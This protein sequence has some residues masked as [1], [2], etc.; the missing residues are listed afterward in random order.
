M[1]NSIKP[2][3]DKN[4]IP[5]VFATDDNF[6]PYLYVAMYSLISNADENNNYDINIL[7]SK[8][9]EH[10][11]SRL[12]SLAQKNISIRFLDMTEYMNK[13]SDV[14]YTHWNYSDAVYYRFF[15]S[16]IFSNYEKVLYLDGDVIFN[17]DIAELYN[18]ELGKNYIAAIQDISQQMQNYVG[19]KYREN[20]LNIKRENYFNAGII[21]FNIKELQKISFFDN[22]ISTLAQLKNPV[23]QD[24]DVLNKV[25]D[26]HVKYLPYNYNL[27]WNCL[28]Y[29]TD[30]K[31][32]MPETTYNE[33]KEAWKNP[34]IIHYAG[35]YKPWKQP[36]LEY[37]D[38]FWKY[39]RQTPFYEE[40][41]YNNCK[42]ETIK[43]V[44]GIIKN[45]IQ[46]QKIYLNYLKCK[47]LKIVT[48]GKAKDHYTQKKDRLKLR[49]KDYRQ[50]LRGKI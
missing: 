48:F 1:I 37:S 19:E 24:Q 31:D 45:V 49:I 9:N 5:I 35:A 16:E 30:A 15:I 41:I 12:A 25:C 23:F 4:Y 8:L 46:R 33:Y 11:I 26:G 47:V 28:H 3:F 27:M 32:R 7:Y 10:N 43:D 13:Y 29:Y 34:K 42:S 36:W 22:C 6:V 50:T 2:I 44:R 18:V 21:V 17:C 40:I 14:W 38:L 20:I 39:A